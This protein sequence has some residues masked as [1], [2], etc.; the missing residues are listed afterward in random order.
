MLDND[1]VY[2]FIILYKVKTGHF[3]ILEKKGLLAYT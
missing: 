3:I 1:S 2:G